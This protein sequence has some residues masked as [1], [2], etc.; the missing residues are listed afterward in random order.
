MCRFFSFAWDGGS[1]FLYSDWVMRQKLLKNK[2]D[3]NPDSHTYIMTHF[4]IN[5]DKQ[6]N[7]ST[8]EY[9]PLTGKFTV[10]TRIE[11]HNPEYAEAWVK[12]LDFKT[13]VPQLIIK[14]IVNPLH[15]RP[16]EV[17]DEDIKLLKEWYSVLDSVGNS[18]WDSV[19]NSVWDSVR[20]SVWDSVWDS[21]GNSVWDYVWDSVGDSVGD[22]V[23]DSVWDSVGNSVSGYISSFFD[24][25]YG[26][27]FSSAVKLWNKELVPSFDGKTWRMH[28]GEKADI[29]FEISNDELINSNK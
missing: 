7:W 4:G 10:D 11:G 21:V 15:G 27:D 16:A 26:Y 6:E 3:E 25:S 24:I 20:N 13:V 9:N 8:Y 14:D 29:V 5:P 28:S 18:V 19:R 23:W 1:N 17:T 12:R 2:S 22:S